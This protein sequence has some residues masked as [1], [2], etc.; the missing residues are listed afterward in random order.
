MQV[1]SSS[2]IWFAQALSGCRG[3]L[4][5]SNPT[6]SSLSQPLGKRN[7]TSHPRQQLRSL[8]RHAEHTKKIAYRMLSDS[9]GICRTA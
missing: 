4:H 6:G 5:D 9:R 7:I 8:P 2:V 3:G 1:E